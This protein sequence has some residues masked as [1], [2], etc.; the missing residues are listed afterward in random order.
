[1]EI[2]LASNNRHK[3][4]EMQQI[5]DAALPGKIKIMTPSDVHGKILDVE[6]NADT[7]EGN[8]YLKAKA[9]F[10][11]TNIP[12]IADDTGL[13]IDALNGAPGVH[14]ARFSGVHGDD[15]ANR[16]KALEL[17]TGKE[18]DER[19]ARF[20]TVICFV[21]DEKEEYIE[22]RCEGRIIFEERGDMGF[23]YDSLFQPEGHER[24][25]AQMSDDEKNAISH[26]GNAVRN[27][28]EFV[29]GN[30]MG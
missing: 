25:F 14:S 29:K 12:C 21:A 5:F 23:G 3:L 2:L 24:T 6:E 11:K 19:T 9:F 1:M 27:F 28:V 26:R 10:D 15:A 20:R 8:A 22:G 13:E 17:L 18:L 4:K 16:K 30:L 7:L